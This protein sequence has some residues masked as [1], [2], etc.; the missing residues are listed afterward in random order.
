VNTQLMKGHSEAKFRAP[1]YSQELMPY[2]DAHNLVA[3]GR[4]FLH[5]VSVRQH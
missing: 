4:H 3:N 5:P 1:V 2:K